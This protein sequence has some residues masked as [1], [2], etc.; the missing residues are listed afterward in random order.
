MTKAYEQINRD[1]EASK[2]GIAATILVN[3]Y[4]SRPPAAAVFDRGT[5]TVEGAREATDARRSQRPGDAE[6]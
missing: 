3:T 4:G 1:T 6:R 2:R 5:S